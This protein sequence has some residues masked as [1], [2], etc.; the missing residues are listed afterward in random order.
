MN[1]FSTLA[2][3]LTLLAFGIHTV[4]GAREFRLFAPSREARGPRRAWVQALAGWHWVSVSLL[5]SAGLFLA[6]GLTDRVP[7]EPTVLLGLA[8]YFAACGLAWLAT[9]AIS[10]GEV[11]RRYLVLGQWVFCFL[12]AGL[13][14]AAA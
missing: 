8:G 12:V 13:A 14:F 3:V 1:L 11:R 10:G 4:A 6:I 2:G 5:A 7:G 9:V